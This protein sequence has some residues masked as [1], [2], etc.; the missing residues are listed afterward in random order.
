MKS[1]TKSRFKTALECPNKLYFTSKKEYPNNKSDDTF[2]QAFASGGFQVEELARL[3]YPSGVFINT[4]NHNYSLAFQLTEE[5]LKQE[6][7]VIYEAAFQFD[8]LFIRTDIIVKK[9]KSIK[10]IE[11]KAK[12]FN[13]QDE[14]IFI[15]KN[16]G[17]VSGWKPYLFDLAFQKF[18][19]QKTFP[20]FKFEAYLLMA[21]KTKK[22]S[23]DGLNQMFRI[24]KNGNPRTDIIKKVSSLSEIGNSILSEINID[25]IINGIISNKYRYHENLDFEESITTFKKAYQEN[26]NWKPVFQELGLIEYIFTG[27]KLIFEE[28]K[29]ALDHFVTHAFVSHDLIWNLIPI[30][31]SFNSSKSDKQP[32]ID[33]YFDKFFNLQKEAFKIVKH[34]N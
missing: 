31:K 13:P 27:N 3:H 21:D 8:G 5:A 30:D 33:K 11:V 24:T 17:L 4:E 2:M 6:N 26:N 12:S 23:I 34:Q 18:V 29:Y 20:Q 1:L 14:N 16:G 9:G 15:G 7:L 32:S 25:D 22:A 10:L 28:K 19:A